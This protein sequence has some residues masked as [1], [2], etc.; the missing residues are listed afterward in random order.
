VSRETKFAEI[1]SPEQFMPVAERAVKLAKERGAEFADATVSVEREVAVEVEK[2]SIKSSEVIWGKSFSVRVYIRG[3]M[4]F[5]STCGFTD[6]DVEPLV[7]R[8]VELARIATPNPDFVALPDPEPAET[9][10][11]VFDPAIL[12]ADSPQAIAWV[13]DNLRQAHS[14][15][16]RV[17]ASGGASFRATGWVLAGSTG[18]QLANKSTRVQAGFFC[19][20]KE[21]GDVGSFAE[22]DSA[23]FL[24]DFVPA[25]LA[26]T[27]THQALKYRHARKVHTNRTTLVLGPLSAISLLGALTGAANAESIQRKRSL[28]ADKIGSV[29]A[30]ELLTI[31]DNG[32][33]DRGLASGAYDGEGA[34]RKVVTLFDRGRFVQPLHNSMTANKA[35]VPNTGHGS[36]TGGISATNLEIALGPLPA[37]ELI[38]QVDDGIYLELGSLDPDLVSGDIST[39][40]DF[41]FKIEKGELAYPVANAM[42]AGN[43]TDVLMN[44][45]A[46]SSDYREEPG[47]RMP[48]LRIRDV[49]VS[50]GGE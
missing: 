13:T 22:H 18:I 40:L 46:V 1:E 39:N 42:V 23:R 31:T 5:A 8:A 45:D 24:C 14:V 7:D 35:K 16:P 17:I 48:T 9:I 26:E 32:L 28:L 29:I 34:K 44:I 38:R 2:T 10:P 19:V 37:A 36:R 3:G 43:L 50:S 49:Q 4:G 21:D 30:P 47:N 11:N 20:V 41:A 15:E 25:G 12:A 33:I 6:A 27:A